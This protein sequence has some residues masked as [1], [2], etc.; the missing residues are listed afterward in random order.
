M[1]GQCRMKPQG[2]IKCKGCDKFQGF[3]K[4]SETDLTDDAMNLSA[5]FSKEMI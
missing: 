1:K 4:T 3:L 2:C 5:A